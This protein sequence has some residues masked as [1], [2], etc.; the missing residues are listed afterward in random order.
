MESHRFVSG[1]TDVC[2]VIGTRDHG[3]ESQCLLWWTNVG[4]MGLHG[5]CFAA[6]DSRSGAP[7]IL[8]GLNGLIL[9]L[10]LATWVLMGFVLLQ[11]IPD[12]ARPQFWACRW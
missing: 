9:G 5:F 11:L 3:S 4:D 6:I 8:L 1:H 12:L 10:S 7:N 2:I